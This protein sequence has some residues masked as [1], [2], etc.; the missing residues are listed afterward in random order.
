MARPVR[1]NNFTEA[2][3][4]KVDSVPRIKRLYRHGPVSIYDLRG[5]GVPELRSGWFRPSRVWAWWPASASSR[6]HC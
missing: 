3:L 2:Q 5:L 4:D 1:E 6:W